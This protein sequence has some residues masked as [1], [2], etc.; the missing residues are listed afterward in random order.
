MKLR[1]IVLMAA[2]PLAILATPC[3]ADAQRAVLVVRH[4]EQVDD[5]TDSLLSEAGQRRAKV[6]KSRVV[7]E[8]I[9]VWERSRVGASAREGYQE[10]ATEDSR[11]PS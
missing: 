6:T 9:R 7:E 2:L 10:M 1:L 11:F 4:A 5:S 3:G 8:A